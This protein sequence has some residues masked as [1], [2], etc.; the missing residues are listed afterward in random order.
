[1]DI[2]VI[3]NRFYIIFRGKFEPYRLPY[4]CR[5]GI[6]AA[7]RGKRLTLLARGDLVAPRI[8]LA[9]NGKRVASLSAKEI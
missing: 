3:F 7:R 1:M 9:I 4:T 5:A 6:E 2:G 8:V